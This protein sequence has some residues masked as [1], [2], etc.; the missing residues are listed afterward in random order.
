MVCLLYL[1]K[2]ATQVVQSEYAMLFKV[3]FI[4]NQWITLV[5]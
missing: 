1:D 4:I 2:R 3:G 5:P